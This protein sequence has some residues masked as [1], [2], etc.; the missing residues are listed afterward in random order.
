MNV[1]VR[2]ALEVQTLARQIK[3]KANLLTDWGI[4]LVVCSN[5]LALESYLTVYL[6]GS[7]RLGSVCPIA[8]MKT[9]RMLGNQ[10]Y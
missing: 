4:C 6:C 7:R 8:S 10:A 9:C 1:R 5:C 3:V 2:Q